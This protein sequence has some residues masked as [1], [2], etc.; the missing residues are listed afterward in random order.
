MQSRRRVDF[1]THFDEAKT[2]RAAIKTIAHNLGTLHSAR[3]CECFPQISV[4]QRKTQIAYEKSY[5]HRF[6]VFA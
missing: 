1:A 5:S 4:T 6:T 3:F 2:P